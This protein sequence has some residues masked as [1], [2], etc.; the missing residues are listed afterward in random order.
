MISGSLLPRR[1]T[2]DFEIELRLFAERH[3]VAVEFFHRYFDTEGANRTAA[4]EDR[5][6]RLSKTPLGD[7]FFIPDV[8]FAVRAPDGAR[9]LYALEMYNG[10]NTKRVHSKSRVS[11]GRRPRRGL[12]R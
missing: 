8:V 1:A 3:G 5:L 10:C 11:A 7:S 2:I 12:P 6:R 9:F 4:P